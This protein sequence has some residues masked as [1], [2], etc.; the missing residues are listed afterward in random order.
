M[1]MLFHLLNL[2][3]SPVISGL[4][5]PERLLGSIL[6]AAHEAARG[7]LQEPLEALRALPR[8]ADAKGVTESLRGFCAA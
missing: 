6:L 4:A 3:I 1:S 2:L 8:K 7:R 5:G